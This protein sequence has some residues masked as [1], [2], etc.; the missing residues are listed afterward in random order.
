MKLKWFFLLLTGMIFST[1]IY[2]QKSFTP[3]AIAKISIKTSAQGSA[4]KDRIERAMAYQIGV[5]SSCL[6]LVNKVIIVSYKPSKTTLEKIKKAISDAGYD[7]D[8]L[9][10]DAKAYAK[11]PASSKKPG[12][13]VQVENSEKLPNL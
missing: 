13:V 1:N 7:A 2:S 3:A 9:A 8:G 6:N 5:V 12:V 11:L 10:A 4:C